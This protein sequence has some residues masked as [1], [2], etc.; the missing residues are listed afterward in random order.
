[1]DLPFQEVEEK[2]RCSIHLVFPSFR[3]LSPQTIHQSSVPSQ[4]PLPMLVAF[5]SACSRL[6]GSSK[7]D[8]Q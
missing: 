8:E 1:M 4:S 2:E 6:D 3:F 7:E 5:I